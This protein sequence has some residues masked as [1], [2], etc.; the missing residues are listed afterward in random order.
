MYYTIQNKH[1]FGNVSV[2]NQYG[3]TVFDSSSHTVNYQRVK[4]VTWN[5]FQWVQKNPQFLTTIIICYK[6]KNDN[7]F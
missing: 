3:I 7:W 4:K 6:L 1:S 2:L 5:M